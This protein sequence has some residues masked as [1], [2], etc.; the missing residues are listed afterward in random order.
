MLIEI[1]DFFAIE[2]KLDLYPQGNFAIESNTKLINENIEKHYKPI[3]LYQLRTGN[4][5]SDYKS[6][7][8]SL[9][10]SG[11]ELPDDLSTYASSNNEISY[12]I[13]SLGREINEIKYKYLGY[14]S[15]RSTSKAI[16]TFCEEYHDNIVFVYY[17]KEY[18]Y[19]W[20]GTYYVLEGNNRVVIREN[21]DMRPWKNKWNV[22]ITYCHATSFNVIGD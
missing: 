19:F 11:I 6:R 21:I 8:Y 20:E 10:G 2:H 14:F 17:M 3:H 13:L 15:D 22:D 5:I 9:S 1:H 16:I 18:I 7:S 4:D 12:I